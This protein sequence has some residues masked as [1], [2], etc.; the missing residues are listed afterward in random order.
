MGEQLNDR[1]EI[2]AMYAGGP[3]QLE[4][5]IAGLSEEDLDITENDGAWTIRQIVHHVVDGDDIWK[6]FIKRAIGNPGGEF[7]LDWYMAIPQCEWVKRWSYATREIGPS[8]ALFR[9][10]RNHIV[11]L[12]EHVPEA[13]ERSLLVRW[14]NGEEQKVQVA[15]VVKMQAQH[16]IG[17]VEDIQRSRLTHDI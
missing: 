14:S 12:L 2:I 9:A 11:Q 8:L 5:A 6:V 4:T 17:H 16:V 7:D 13:W 1:E 10:N 3:I 15:W